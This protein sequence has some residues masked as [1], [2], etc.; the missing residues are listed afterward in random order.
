M[1]PAQIRS[2][3]APEDA[4]RY[5]V[6]GCWD[7]ITPECSKKLSGEFF[8]LLRPLE[9]A[10]HRPEAMQNLDFVFDPMDDASTFEEFYC[11]YLKNVEKVIRAKAELT[12]TGSRIW[13]K[14][15]PVCLVSALMEPCI[16]NKRDLTDGGGRYN[17]ECSYFLAFPDVVDS[18]LAVKTLC[19]DEH[20]CTLPAL[21]DACRQNW[22]DERLRQRAIAAPSY[23]DGTEASAQMAARLHN[24]LYRLTRDLPTAYG[25]QYHIGYN[26]YTEVI[27]YGQATAATPNGRRSGAYLSQSLTPSRLQAP[28]AV[29]DTF[30]AISKLD[31]TASSGNSVANLLLPL[32]NMTTDHFTALLRSA[33]QSG[34][35]ALQINCVDRET[36][37]AAQKDP[38]QHRDIIVRVYG[39]SAPFVSLS[40]QYQEEFLS[41][42]F[43]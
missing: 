3:I 22:P 10:I 13:H 43:Y 32:R 38:D 33:A 34:A 39:F 16:P 20:L 6:G 9:W 7:V 15:A 37:L 21:L 29:T 26:I 36:L 5:V 18:L 12:A 14:V 30:H 23:G 42:N 27:R 40:P 17:W 41:R 25:G 35:Q 31:L 4:C 8:H 19:F 2:G 28:R 1:I 11:I 24:D